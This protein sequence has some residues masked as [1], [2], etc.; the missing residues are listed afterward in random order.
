MRNGG[1]VRLAGS[2]R[3]SCSAASLPCASRHSRS[4]MYMSGT[5]KAGV[6]KP[7]KAKPTAGFS[8]TAWYTPASGTQAG[9]PHERSIV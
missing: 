2:M 9:R 6:E 1:P 5:W 4:M 3:R 7:M 8:G